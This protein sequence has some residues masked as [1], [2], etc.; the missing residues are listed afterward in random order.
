MKAKVILQIDD[1][2]D[3]CELFLEALK[4]FP[5]AG[6]AAEYHAMY[7][8]EQALATLEA[9]RIL[10]DIIFLDL[11]MPRMNGR[12][13]LTAIKTKEALKDIPVLIFSTSEAREMMLQTEGL[14]ATGYI[15]KPNDIKVLQKTIRESISAYAAAG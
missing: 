15:T 7:D 2:E 8:A 6:Y 1:D 3:D 13:F 10:P 14:G 12:E 11:N 4:S 9:G 5:E